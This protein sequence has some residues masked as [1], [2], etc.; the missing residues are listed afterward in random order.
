MEFTDQVRNAA[1]TMFMGQNLELE[2][3]IGNKSAATSLWTWVLKDQFFCNNSYNVV[4]RVPAIPSIQEERELD[5]A[6]QILGKLSAAHRMAYLM[7][8]MGCGQHDGQRAMVE[9]EKLATKRAQQYLD[10]T[11]ERSVW[12]MTFVGVGMRLWAHTKGR[13]RPVF[14]DASP[15]GTMGAYRTYKKNKHELLRCFS[16]VRCCEAYH[17]IIAYD[18]EG[19]QTHAEKLN[20]IFELHGSRDEIS[21]SRDR[22]HLANVAMP[23]LP[24]QPRDE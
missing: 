23:P 12:I 22:V 6:V 11:G 17:Y 24:R 5:I 16:Q 8:G 7:V 13:T 4:S 21:K 20:V 18:V 15:A 14:P 19:D 10:V 9:M 2:A 3:S 1:V